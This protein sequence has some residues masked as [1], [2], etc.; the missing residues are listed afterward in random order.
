MGIQEIAISHGKQ[1]KYVDTEHRH[2]W[3]EQHRTN[4][5]INLHKLNTTSFT[6]AA[7]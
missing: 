3:R 1:E 6:P 4:Q 7:N 2:F 5:S